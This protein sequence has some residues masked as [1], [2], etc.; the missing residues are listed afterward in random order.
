[1]TSTQKSVACLGVI[2]FLS[3]T[4]YAQSAGPQINHF[5]GDGISFDYPIGW[6]ISDEST[7]EAQRLILTYKGSSVWLEIVA[8]RGFVLRN[9]LPG[10]IETFTE[11]ILKKVAIRVGQNRQPPQRTV[12]RT[13]VGLIEAE[14]VRLQVTGNTKIGE[15][16]WLRMHFRLIS[17]AL[18]RSGKDESVG[19]KLWQRILATLNVEGP[20]LA[21]KTAGAEPSGNAKVE[22]GVLN[23]KALELPRPEYPSIARAARASGTVTVQVV[24][25]EQGNVSAAH[26][27]SGHPLLQAV[28]LAAA[29]QAKFFPTLLEGEP[30]KVTGV[31]TYNF[32]H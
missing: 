26:V 2:W 10:A 23:G 16:I 7:P 9:E 27:V 20:V 4:A 17:I 22:S 11:P 1:V 31:I 13:Q 6:S 21:A 15:V 12:I 25:D 14:G 29:R 19:S 28:S 30:V 3:F 32:M 24:I 8:K 18:V 5:A